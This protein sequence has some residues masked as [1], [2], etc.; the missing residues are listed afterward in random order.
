MMCSLARKKV[1]RAT[2]RMVVTQPVLPVEI[3][4][5]FFL[6]LVQHACASNIANYPLGEMY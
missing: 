5:R 4:K 2:Y 1:L 3:P 6:A